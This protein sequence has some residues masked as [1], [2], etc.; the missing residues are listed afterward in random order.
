[1]PRSVASL[2]SRE[3]FAP[4]ADPVNENVKFSLFHALVFRSEILHNLSA[5]PSSS[6]Y[7]LDGYYRWE[8]AHV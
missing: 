3:N 1:M 7:S 6:V 5:Y 2:L 4:K 8:G